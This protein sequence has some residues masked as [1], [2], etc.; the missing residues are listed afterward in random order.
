M[1]WHCQL[2]QAFPAAKCDMRIS[3]CVQGPG[4][5]SSLLSL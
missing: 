1:N 2:P 5:L 4:K 3:S